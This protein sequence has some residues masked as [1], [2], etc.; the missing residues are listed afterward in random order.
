MEQRPQAGPSCHAAGTVI[1]CAAGLLRLGNGVN[2]LPPGRVDLWV[3]RGI[4]EATQRGVQP[5]MGAQSVVVAVTLTEVN[6]Q[7]GNV[8]LVF[9]GSRGSGR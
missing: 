7:E 4:G 6:L 1:L 3:H 2:K 5:V 9:P 8:I